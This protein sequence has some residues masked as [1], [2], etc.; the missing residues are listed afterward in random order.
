MKIVFHPDFH[1]VYVSDPAA[2]K[3]R[4]A[5]LVETLKPKFDFIYPVPAS[6]QDIAR[7]HGA[8][9]IQEVSGYRKVGPLAMLAAGGA[10]TAART[11]CRGEPAFALI[12]PP[13]H[14]AGPDSCW[15]FCY[16][17]NM[18]IAVG[19]LL[20]E[21]AVQTAVILDIDLHFGDG[22][23]NYFKNSKR[24][25][26]LNPE[27][28]D[29][30]QFVACCRQDLGFAGPADIIAVSAGFDRHYEDWGGQLFTEDYRTIGELVKEYADTHCQ[31][32]RFAVLE[33]GYN[34]QAMA[35][36]TLALLEGMA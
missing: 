15:G 23:D 3:G 30:R 26:V 33:G 20:A 19:A 35:E 25:E 34:H 32:R 36:A 6:Q 10:I 8:A 14:H 13:G 27:G 18:A 2:E 16:Y 7:V 24:V 11:A 12:R 17:N 21:E 5:P 28:P 1:K 22:T 31:G 9:H 29:G 4:L